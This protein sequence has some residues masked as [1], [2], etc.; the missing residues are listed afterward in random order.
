MVPATPPA[1]QHTL[2][3]WSSATDAGT[4]AAGGQNAAQ[5]GGD[6]GRTRTNGLA[7]RP[8]RRRP[9]PLP[10]APSVAEGDGDTSAASVE[11]R[12]DG[13]EP[14]SDAERPS[15]G[16]PQPMWMLRV[17]PA[18]QKFRAKQTER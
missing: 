5:R 3:P 12:I 13:A 6:G 16:A 15:R 14:Q 2:G 17:P 10:A 9:C 4:A 18:A 7:A 8:R 11:T 1:P